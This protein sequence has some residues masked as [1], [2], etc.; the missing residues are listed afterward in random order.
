ME[1]DSSVSMAK[2]IAIILMVLAHTQFS[3]YGDHFIAMFHMPLFFFFSGFVFKEKHLLDSKSY[4]IKK[5]NGIYRP[6]VKWSLFF[7]ALHNLL[8]FLN[9]YDSSYTIG[10]T[11]KRAVYIITAMQDYDPLLGGFWFLRTLMWASLFSFL[12]IK[13]TCKTNKRTIAYVVGGGFC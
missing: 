5:I 2:G 1:R 11:V 8:V 6:F 4:V 7:L 3:L 9:I 12:F 10:E 13:I